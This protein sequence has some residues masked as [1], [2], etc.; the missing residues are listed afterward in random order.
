MTSQHPT[1][2]RRLE[3]KAG[4]R[5][6]REGGYRLEGKASTSESA[7]IHRPQLQPR[8]RG[9]HSELSRA[10]CAI[11]SVIGPTPRAILLLPFSARASWG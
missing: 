1:S 2:P 4:V 10:R 6:W 7:Q 9:H 8:R 3:P 5:P 11:S